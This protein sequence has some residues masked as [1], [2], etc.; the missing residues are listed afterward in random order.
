MKIIVDRSSVCMG[1]DV[2]SHER[3]VDIE[4]SSH[5]VH[6]LSM[7]CR[8]N[9]FADVSGNNVVWVLMAGDHPILAYYTRT[10][11]VSRLASEQKISD[12][13]KFGKLSFSY[14]SSPEKWESVIKS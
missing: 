6:L 10:G 7:L 8:S 9:F 13:R 2:E 14:Y 1:D 12:I 11:A 5:A 4:D 3:T